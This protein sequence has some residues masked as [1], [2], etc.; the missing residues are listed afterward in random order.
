MIEILRAVMKTVSGTLLSLVLRIIAVK[1]IAVMLGPSGVGLFSVL[2][3]IRDVSSGLGT[4]GGQTALVQGLASREDQARDDYLVTAFWIFTAGALLTAGVLV[5]FAPFLSTLVFGARNESNIAL[6]RGLAVPVALGVLVSYLSGVMNGFRAVGRLAVV[7]VI[8]AVV[9]VA[10]AYPVSLLVADGHPI[11]FVVMMA[12]SQLLAAVFGLWVAVKQ[13]WLKPLFSRS[14][15]RVDPEAFRHFSS[16]AGTT[17][18]TVLAMTGA[19][20]AVRSLVLRQDGLAAAGV[21]DAAWTLSMVYVM[22]LMSSFS[23]Y[24]LPTLSRTEDPAERV[25][26]MQRILRLSVLALVPMITAVVVLKPLIIE[27]LYSGE[28]LPALETIRW[29]LIGDYFKVG[30]WILSMPV[31]AYA[32]MRIFFFTET[33]W[34]VGFVTLSALAVFG[35]DSLEGIGVGF[36]VLYGLYMVYYFG[37]SRARHGF[38]MSALDRIT[39]A[40]GLLLI[41]AVSWYTW[42]DTEVYWLSAGVWVCAAC[43][44]SILFLSGSERRKGLSLL[45]SRMVRSS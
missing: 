17:L 18:F 2:R 40:V 24:Y 16:F 19:I 30:G 15:A 26:L 27:S 37:Y 42:S 1:I 32:D 6:T 45:K 5:V 4:V 13:G 39:W 23:A 9:M 7:Q 28:F 29:M 34:S 14:R 22:L 44:F 12:A 10:A 21:F 43:G 3:Q 31:L 35:F 36:L 25:L 38:R 11:A 8:G 33:L 41:V 20:L